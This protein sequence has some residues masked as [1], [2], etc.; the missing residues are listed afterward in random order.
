[1]AGAAAVE[2]L[3]H[4]SVATYVPTHGAVVLN[5]ACKAQNREHDDNHANDVEDILR[6]HSVLSSRPR[7]REKRSMR[8]FLLVAAP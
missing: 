4:R 5:H 8:A 6:Y 3:V 7:L 1:M 2:R